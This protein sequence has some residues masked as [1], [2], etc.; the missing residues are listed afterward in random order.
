M[1]K[2]FPVSVELS[3]HSRLKTNTTH[4]LVLLNQQPIWHELHEDVLSTPCKTTYLKSSTRLLQQTHTMRAT[5]TLS[6]AMKPRSRGRLLPLTRRKMREICRVPNRSHVLWS[7]RIA[8]EL[9]HRG[10]EDDHAVGTRMRR[11]THWR[12]E[13]SDTAPSQEPLPL[14]SGLRGS[15]TG[16]YRYC[17]W[18]SRFEARGECDKGGVVR[19]GLMME[20]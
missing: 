17:C 11:S 4:P 14:Q 2:P 3:R 1:S 9:G 7:D 8:E 12:P 6:V 20:Q 13:R 10:C 16:C 5:C 19:P 15:P 18:M